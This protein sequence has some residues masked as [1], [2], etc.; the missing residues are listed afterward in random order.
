MVQLE[1]S[2]DWKPMI[3]SKVGKLFGVCPAH[4]DFSRFLEMRGKL[5]RSISRWSW[6]IPILTF[7]GPRN[8]R[9]R[10]WFLATH[11]RTP[12]KNPAVFA[13]SFMPFIPLFYQFS[14]FPLHRP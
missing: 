13:L 10:M 11:S 7:Y 8:Q 6:K 5:L 4:K 9:V 14:C 1:Y 3:T 12:E 2:R